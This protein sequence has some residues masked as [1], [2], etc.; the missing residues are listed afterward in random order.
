MQFSRPEIINRRKLK[1]NLRIF[2]LA[3]CSVYCN[4]NG[5]LARIK[6]PSLLIQVRAPYLSKTKLFLQVIFA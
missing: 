1:A 6:Q 5:S 2:L 3:V 4:E